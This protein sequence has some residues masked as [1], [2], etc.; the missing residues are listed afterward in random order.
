MSRLR[1]L[2]AGESHGP[3]LT[4][5]LEGLPADIHLDIHAVD[6]DLA[7]RQRGFGSGGRMRIEHD[8]ARFTSGLMAGMTTGA[9]LAVRVVNRDFANWRTK[10]VEPMTVPR[11]GHADLV[12]ALKYDPFD[13]RHSLERASARETTTRVIVGAVCKQLLAACG[14]RIGGYVA[15]LGGVQLDVPASAEDE[16]YLARAKVA[17]DNDLSLPDEGRYDAGHDEVQAAMKAK[18][19]LGGV[20]EVFALGLPPGLGSYVHYDRRLDARLA[21]AM[22]SIQAMKGVEI[23]PAFENASKRGTDVHDELFVTKGG[24]IVRETNRAGGL[25]GG[26]TTGAPLVV[27]VAM[28]PISTTLNPRRSVDLST[29]EP[30]ETTYERSDFCALPR[31]VVIAESMLAF[32]LAD[33]LLERVGGDTLDEIVERA[34]SLRRS[35]VDAVDLDGAPFRFNYPELHEDDV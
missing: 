33:A 26:M 34:A 9:P 7:R 22:L 12:G 31:A 5:V 2:N 10:T 11:P 15:R 4:C 19:T 32:T 29:G 17:L 25:E 30:A 28:K 6:A 18:D 24:D 35:R 16:V 1:F 14:V 3:E 27:R 21:H 8:R 23:G 13:L 20:L